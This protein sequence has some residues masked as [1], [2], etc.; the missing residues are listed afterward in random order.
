[1]QNE[2]ALHSTKR[3]TVLY[4]ESSCPG[5]HSFQSMEENEKCWPVGNS[6]S[7][8]ADRR[9][10]LID[11]V[12]VANEEFLKPVCF[13]SWDGNMLDKGWK[14]QSVLLPG[15]Q[16]TCL[17][18]DHATRLH[19]ALRPLSYRAH[20]RR[21]NFLLSSHFPPFH[22]NLSSA[23]T[24]KGL[25]KIIPSQCHRI[26]L[27]QCK[28]ERFIRIGLDNSQMLSSTPRQVMRKLQQK[29]RES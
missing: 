19:S 14:V 4:T 26:V 18:P 11:Q 6:Q 10:Q 29:A 24:N 1:M 28:G 7:W 21:L 23:S 20:A 17:P 15:T 27:I 13:G 25:K 3:G 5:S 16:S 9:S 8:L 22:Q 2:R 12:Q